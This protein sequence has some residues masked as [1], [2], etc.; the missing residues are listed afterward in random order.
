MGLCD[1]DDDHK[2]DKK[3]KKK[4]GVTNKSYA[5]EDDIKKVITIIIGV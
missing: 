5:F 3:K 4:A 1:F 2:M